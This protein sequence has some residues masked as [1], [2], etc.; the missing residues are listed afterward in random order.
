ML[1]LRRQLA[2]DGFLSGTQQ[3]SRVRAQTEALQM[4]AVSDRSERCLD[5]DAQGGGVVLRRQALELRIPARINL[6]RDRASP[7]RVSHLGTHEQ[8]R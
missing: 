4:K 8:S 3:R 2:S 7:L 1:G 6:A 5:G